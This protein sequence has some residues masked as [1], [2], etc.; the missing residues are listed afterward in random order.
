MSESNGWNQLLPFTI[1][2]TH[3]FSFVFQH[4]AY[5]FFAHQNNMFITEL[6]FLL[7]ATSVVVNMARTSSRMSTSTTESSPKKSSPKKKDMTSIK[8]SKAKPMRRPTYVFKIMKLK[9]DI[10]V[11]WC[12]KTPHDDAFIHPLI[13]DIEENDAFRDHGIVGITR[14]RAGR[15]DN[16]LLT[17]G[18]DGYPRRLIVRVVDESTHESRTAILMVLRQFMMRPENNRYSYEYAVNEASDLTP[19]DEDMLEPV[20][21]YIPD[22]SIVNIITAV[23][24]TADT[25]WYENNIEIANDYFA[26]QPYPRSAIDQLGFPETQGA[27]QRD[28]IPPADM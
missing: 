25:H 17:N 5:L 3:L 20:N 1:H 23:F 7:A 27:F 13:K 18:I 14:R 8:L 6:L 21:A 12:E 9:A 16:S 22:Y 11:I 10:E 26:D 28:F 2:H 24:E 15:L 19:A 4:G